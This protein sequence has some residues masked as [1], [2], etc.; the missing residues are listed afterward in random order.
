MKQP[1]ITSI[2]KTVLT[3]LKPGRGPMVN[4]KS[5]ISPDRSTFSL[6]LTIKWVVTV[7]LPMPPILT[8]KYLLTSW[9]AGSDEKR[10][11]RLSEM[12]GGLKMISLSIYGLLKS[13]QYQAP[14]IE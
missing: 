8:I 14:F 13:A 2:T 4:L 7:K 12:Y 1:D 10:V 11:N 3:K 9:S 6:R 5:I